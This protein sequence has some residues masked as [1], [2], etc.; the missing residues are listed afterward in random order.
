MCIFIINLPRKITIHL[1]TDYRKRIYHADDYFILPQI[2]DG[3]GFTMRM[4]FLLNTR[5]VVDPLTKGK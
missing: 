5:F 4:V 2:A 3:H 1:Q